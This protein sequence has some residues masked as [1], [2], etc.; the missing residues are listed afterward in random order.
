M[1]ELIALIVALPYITLIGLYVYCTALKPSD[2]PKTLE[3]RAY[4]GIT[5]G[6]ER[7]IFLLSFLSV[8]TLPYD[9]FNESGHHITRYFT[10]ALGIMGWVWF[11]S[12]MVNGNVKKWYKDFRA[13]KVTK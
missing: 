9:W 11:V 5:K 6:I 2:I 7:I 12:N 1:V 4:F 10:A 13:K 3:K 8:L